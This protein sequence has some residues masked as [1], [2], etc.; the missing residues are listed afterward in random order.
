MSPQ[1]N[2]LAS[3]ERIISCDYLRVIAVFAV[4]LMH[5]TASGFYSLDISAPGWLAC[6]AWNSMTRFCVPVFVMISGALFLNPDRQVSFRQLFQKNILR[7]VTA[8]LFWSALYAIDTGIQAGSVNSGIAAFISGHYHLWF[9]NLMIGLYLI[10]PFLRKITQSENLTVYFLVLSLFSAIVIPRAFE[11]IEELQIPGLIRLLPYVRSAYTKLNLHFPLGCTGYFLLGYFLRSHALTRCQQ[12]I[13]Y[14]L[15]AASFVFILGGTVLV[16]RRQGSA[17]DLLN[18]Y[19]SLPVL[20]ESTAVFVFSQ[21]HL[22]RTPG[23]EKGYRFLLRLSKC[24]FGIYLVHAFVLE[25]LEG[26][27]AQGIPVL[28]IPVAAVGVFVISCAI[29]ALLHRIP[30]LNRYIV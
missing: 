14:L 1:N 9:L 3:T 21:N 11:W 16:S 19:L 25:K 4:I 22:A 18:G 5:T 7:L 20:F 23:S 26:L 10:V 27:F 6:S 2:T 8:Y 24:S 13:C 28:F 15:G 29:T 12:K 30:V 17:S